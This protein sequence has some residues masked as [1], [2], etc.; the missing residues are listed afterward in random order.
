MT[1]EALPAGAFTWGSIERRYDADPSVHWQRCEADGLGWPQ[2]V[3]TQ[4]FHEDAH[5][6]NFATIVRAV[7]WGRVRWE[8][9][10]LSGIA[11]RQVCVDRRY[12][13]AL[14]EA[15]P[16]DPVWHHR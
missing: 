16:S 10:D 9:E 15:R 6:A 2:E 12:K 14:D 7:D 4:L 5:Y 11:L 8:L 1:R 3:F 13:H